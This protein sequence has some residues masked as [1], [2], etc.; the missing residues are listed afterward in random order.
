ME[1]V[2]CD[3]TVPYVEARRALLEL[4]KAK[5]ALFAPT[6]AEFPSSHPVYKGIYKIIHD[7]AV[8]QARMLA[9]GSACAFADIHGDWLFQKKI[10]GVYL[11]AATHWFF[12]LRARDT[13]DTEERATTERRLTKNFGMAEAQLFEEMQVKTF[14]FFDEVSIL[15]LISIVDARQLV[16]H[17]A[18]TVRLFAKVTKILEKHSSSLVALRYLA[19][20]PNDIRNTVIAHCGNSEQASSSNNRDTI[21]N[22]SGNLNHDRVQGRKRP[23]S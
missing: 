1:N 15:P 4:W 23:R 19:G 9:D 8:Q 13:R 17:R 6:Q 5:A 11:H 7:P 3:Q 16:R 10:D 22:D 18:S 21:D 20:L 2:A 12:G 14:V